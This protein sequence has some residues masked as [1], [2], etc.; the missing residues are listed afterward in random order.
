MAY[1]SRSDYRLLA[2]GAQVFYRCERATAPEQRYLLALAEDVS[3]GGLFIGTHYPPRPG[4]VVRLHLYAG[5]DHAHLSPLTAKAIVRWRRAWGRQRGMGVQFL[6]FEGL[7]ARR[8]ESWMETLL[9]ADE[10]TAGTSA[11]VA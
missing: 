6:E 5:D 7:G 2:Y 4:T 8:L 11:A 3:M 10:T 9:A 1:E